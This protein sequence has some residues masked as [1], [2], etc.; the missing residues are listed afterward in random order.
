METTSAFWVWLLA[1]CFCLI[2]SQTMQPKINPSRLLI[3]TV[4]DYDEDFIIRDTFTLV[5]SLRLH[6]GDLNNATFTVCIPLNFDSPSFYE[7]NGLIYN[8]TALGVEIAFIKQTQ[9]P[10]QKTLNKFGAFGV[11]DSHRFDYFLW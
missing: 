8:L 3:A 2:L 10:L 9:S 7:E 5:R 4:L 11:F 1:S 6:G